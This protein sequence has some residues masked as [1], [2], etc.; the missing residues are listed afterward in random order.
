MS[1]RKLKSKWERFWVRNG[2]HFSQGY[3]ESYIWA[4]NADA[5]KE[6]STEKMYK[7]HITH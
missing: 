5:A 7:Q 3:V 2:R 1:A 6:T 4:M